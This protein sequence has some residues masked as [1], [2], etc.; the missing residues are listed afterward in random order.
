[1]V[2][3]LYVDVPTRRQPTLGLQR[4]AG[5]GD[6]DDGGV[7]PRA[8]TYREDPMLIRGRPPRGPA[9][10]QEGHIATQLRCAPR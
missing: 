8:D 2:C 7:N 9:S 10:L 6:I 3:E 1:M 5:R 4:N